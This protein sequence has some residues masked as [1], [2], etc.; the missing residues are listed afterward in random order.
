MTLRMVRVR[1]EV[2][3]LCAK[4]GQKVGVL[5]AT[6]TDT[7]MDNEPGSVL[8]IEQTGSDWGGSPY[9][10]PQEVLDEMGLSVSQQGGQFVTYKI[11]LNAW[12]TVLVPQGTSVP[13]G[14]DQVTA[15]ELQAAIQALRALCEEWGQERSVEP[16]VVSSFLG[17]VYEGA[18]TSPGDIPYPPG[19]GL[20]NRQALQEIGR[21]FVGA[22]YTDA[23]YR[24]EGSVFIS[25]TYPR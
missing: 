3:E 15:E 25:L 1:D 5:G 24:I 12:I 17:N 20:A 11:G 2:L 6:V 4:S 8:M 22:L 21:D 7:L 16:R 10:V 14:V 13:A 23:D 18:G 9:A 19:S